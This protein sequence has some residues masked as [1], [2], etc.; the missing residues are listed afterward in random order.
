[1]CKVFVFMGVALGLLVLGAVQAAANPVGIPGHIILT[2]DVYGND[3]IINDPQGTVRVYVFLS[4]YA[5]MNAVGCSFAAPKPACFNAVYVGETKQFTLTL[6]DSQSGMSIWFGNCIWSPVYLLRIT[7]TVL[8]PTPQ[9]CIYWVRP[10]PESESGR[11]EIWRC[12]DT[13]HYGDPGY[14]I[15]NSDG[16]QCQSALPV[17]DSTWGKVKSL[18]A[19]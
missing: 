7:Y 3:T 5:M 9:C 2:E 14:M 10:H 6:G 12:D 1:M 8:G 16:T 19:Q 18:Y 13:V 15:F 17:E 4:Q 11:I